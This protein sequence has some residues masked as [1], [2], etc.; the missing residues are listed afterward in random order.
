[1]G[2]GGMIVMDEDTCMVD[3]AKYF[4]NFLA[5]ESC[6]KCV[7][8]REGLIR[9]AEILG[10]ITGGEGRPGDLELIEHLS[11]TIAEVSLCALGGSA[12]NPVMS[13]VKYFREEYETHI[14]KKKCP[15]HVCKALIKFM[16][17]DKCNGCTLCARNCPSNCIA[18]NK[19]ELHVI[20]Q[21][22]CIR[23]G[24]CREVCKFAAVDVD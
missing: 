2:S 23:C 13:T 6:G 1:M 16:I 5:D 8:C 4:T 3:V 11:E 21:A 15:A 12:P 7:S 20:D 17:N 14:N 24:V 22:K 9:M 19:K 18:G 10:R